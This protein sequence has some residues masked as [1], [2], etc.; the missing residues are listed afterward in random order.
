MDQQRKFEIAWHSQS[1]HTATKLCF[2][3]FSE[4]IALDRPKTKPFATNLEQRLDVWV[5]YSGARASNG[6]S[7]DDRLETHDDVNAGVLGLLDMIRL[8]LDPGEFGVILLSFPLVRSRLQHLI[9]PTKSPKISRT[10]MSG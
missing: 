7:L 1:I 2:E 8:K 5:R 3:R 9:Y 6:L 4:Y 10:T